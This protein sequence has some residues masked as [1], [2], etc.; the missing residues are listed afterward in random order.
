VS[1]GKDMNRE[2]Q[3]ARYGLQHEAATDR[4]RALLA[5][6]ANLAHQGPQGRP[7]RTRRRR[8]NPFR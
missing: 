2:R 8:G 6:F 7:K 4:T 5:V 3:R 1:Y